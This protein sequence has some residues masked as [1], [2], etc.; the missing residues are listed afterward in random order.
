MCMRTAYKVRI[1]PTD[2]QAAI[3]SRTFGCVRVAWNQTLA[4]RNAR[5]YLDGTRTN[6]TDANTFLTELKRKAEFEWLNEVSSVPLQ[7]TIRHQ[8]VAF[9]NFF[10]KR[11]RFPRFKSR[12]GRQSAEFTRSAFRWKNGEFWL[13]KMDHPMRF[14]WS[15]PEVDVTSINPTTV[16]ISREPCGRWYASLAVEVTDPAPLPLARSVVGVDVGI[17]DFA[18][19]SD[20]EKIANPKCLSRK[21]R[22]LA[23][24]QR[25]MA[26]KQKG[27]ANREKA[28]AKVARA[29]RKV[30]A[31]R[32]DFLHRTSTNLV[33]KHDV[34]VI[35]DLAVK[36][37]VKNRK[38]SKA[39]SDSGWRSF[40]T[41][42][43]YK[44]ER[45]GR[46]VVAINRWFPSSKTCSSC[47]HL[48]AQLSLST[49]TWTCPGCSTLHDRDVNAAKN[50]KVA[51]G[52]A[53]S[54]CGGDVSHSGFSRMQL[55]VKQESPGFSYGE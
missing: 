43:E 32:R 27:S 28:R 15:W 47:G 33:R 3:L 25:Q 13:A 22:N 51:A 49:R 17:K 29:H 12:N 45:A 44:A 8:Q 34:I 23:R 5:F 4:W 55:P 48:L 37:M 31:S 6:F 50:I 35:E 10:S 7:Q 18:V 14:V 21:E 24:Y 9:T 40:R 2:E 19:T 46:Q 11:A 39:I 20:G 42:L 38:L 52:L 16:T 36:N 41:M 54:A 26:R 30:R 53:V 1:Y